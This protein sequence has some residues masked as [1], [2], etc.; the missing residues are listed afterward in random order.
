MMF[1]TSSINLRNDAV[2]LEQNRAEQQRIDS[3]FPTIS[4]NRIGSNRKS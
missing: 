1:N 2:A 3:S 4:E